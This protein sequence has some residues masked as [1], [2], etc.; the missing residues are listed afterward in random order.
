MEASQEEPKKLKKT[1]SF[2]VDEELYSQI[3]ASARRAGESPG[4]LF[5]L[6]LSG[7]DIPLQSPRTEDI[8]WTRILGVF[9]KVERQLELITAQL[10]ERQSLDDG[11]DSRIVDCLEELRR[12]NEF[13]REAA[14]NAH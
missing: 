6:L 13:I 3:T 11:Q 14:G 12:I 1:L 7:K 9:N 5:R 4:G 8:P 10:L 2:R